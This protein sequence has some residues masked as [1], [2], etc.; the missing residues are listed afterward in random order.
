MSV[1]PVADRAFMIYRL[2]ALEQD[3][4]DRILARGI[5][6]SDVTGIVAA[7]RRVG[8][9]VD[10]D[11]LI[12]S[13]FK[14]SPHY[15]SRYP[16]PFPPGRYSDGS[17]P[18][19]YSALNERTALAEMTHTVATSGEY[20][21]RTFY[22]R[23]FTCQYAGTTRDF[24]TTSPSIPEM[25]ADKVVG[26]PFCQAIGAT[27]RKDGVDGL[28]VPSARNRE[29]D[30][31]CT[32]VLSQASLQSPSPHD[33]AGIQKARDKTIIVGASKSH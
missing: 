14:A 11:A 12:Q 7:L 26:W 13:K 1:P 4:I 21:E 23:V 22:F 10:A 20:S 6:A 29:A 24:T 19:F 9:P 32:P 27:A 16:T 2:A 25:I 18:V 17:F 33:I 28:V 5:S 31:I 15:P 3:P 30:G 8:V